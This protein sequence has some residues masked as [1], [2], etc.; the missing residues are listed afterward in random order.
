MTRLIEILLGLEPGF[1]AR[2]GQFEVSFH[3][4]WP[5]AESIGNAT[6][7]FLLVAA[8]VALVVWV[9]RREG[10][11]K[12][13]RIALAAGRL[14]ILLLLITLLSRPAISLT[15]ARIE[16]SVLAVLVDDS[17]SM[18]VRDVPTD[19]DPETRAAT[20]ANLWTGDTGLAA[21][22]AGDHEIRLFSMSDRAT[23]VE[24]L[25]EEPTG[26]TTQ[27]A[28][29]TSDA[30]RQL[31]GQNLAG[32]LLLTDGKDAPTSLS[33][34]ALA[35][36]QQAGVPLFPMPIGGPGEPKNLEIQ[37]VLAQETAF[38]GD[39]VNIDTVLRAA[40]FDAPTDV[41]LTVTDTSGTPLVDSAG[42]PV[43]T[44]ATLEPGVATDVELPLETA[45]AGVL[46]LLL[47][48]EPIDSATREIDDAD[49]VRPLQID[50]L[51]AQIAVLYVEGY[52]RWE[53]R[54]LKNQI[55]R[56]ST[57]E[58]S[59]LL[60]SADPTF[61]QEGDRP[62][63]RF[64]VTLE[65]LLTY[66]VVLLGDVSPNQ[67][68][69]GQLQLLEEFVGEAGGGFGM[70]A[71]P[72]DSPWAWAGTPIERLLPVDIVAEPSVSLSGSASL[73]NGWRPKLTE[74]GE[75]SGIYRFFPSKERN[76]DYIDDEAPLLYWWA[77]G[78]T[79]RPG[80][81]EVLA[82]HPDETGPDGLPAPLLVVG[83]YGAGRTLFNGVDDAWRW[84]YYTGESIFDTFWVQQLRYLARGK[85]L[86]QRRVALDVLRPTYQ[87]GD[88]VQVDV[89]VLDP[90]LARELPDRLQADVLNEDG[91]PRGKISLARRAAG[92]DSA[93]A[94]YTASFP[95]DRIGRYTVRLPALSGEVDE[96]TAAVTVELPDAEMARPIV[97]RQA[98][99]RLA[100]QT[101]GQVIPL[102]E[103]G[104]AAN[105]IKSVEKRVPI[106][107]S[108]SLWD[109][110]LALMLFTAFIAFEWI[111]RKVAGLI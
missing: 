35:E 81:G 16:P 31:R 48:V 6:W 110:P 41:R 108:R 18:R 103:A 42:N 80:V 102:A 111:G 15:Q 105:R 9:Y 37:S 13:W 1:L 74:A 87:L 20:V 82:E 106:V 19:G 95:A 89:R 66:D 99:Q 44:V 40:G 38:A 25:P 23:S 71:G 69:D 45:Q 4:S 30:L 97:D 75:R 55:I 33:A 14:S 53:Y 107:T 5:L 72:N 61:A 24:T 11:T 47:R 29:A 78:I 68:A 79:A 54:Y 32:V 65:E 73:K 58:A 17:L 63:R 51:D 7:N 39:L 70:V 59:I 52:P 101:G 77:D 88:L 28:A 12:R 94:R 46:D 27:V 83:R 26:Q 64:P 36:L 92:G 43:Q 2:D 22:L 109:A 85:K 60:T 49:N 84:R 50:V 90:Q 93:Q 21:S 10:K 3:P 62:I 76:A 104:E 91:S 57:V 8:A 34:T 98:L 96:K 86:G 100:E 56:D 67:F